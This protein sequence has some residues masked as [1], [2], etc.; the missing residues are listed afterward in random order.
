MPTI[1]KL[2]DNAYVSGNVALSL[3]KG[4]LVIFC[5]HWTW[6]TSSAYLYNSGSV[7]IDGVALSN[8]YAQYIA[9]NGDAKG[10]YMAIF[11]Y[12]V[13]SSGSV[14]VSLSPTDTIAQERYIQL[15]AIEIVPSAG[16]QF[17][18][19]AYFVGSATRAR[20]SST[21]THPIAV[22]NSKDDI[23]VGL[24]YSLNSNSTLQIAWDSPATERVDMYVNAYNEVSVAT[25]ISE[26]DSDVFSYTQ[27][28]GNYNGAVAIAVRELS[29]E[30]EMIW[31]L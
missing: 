26:N 6:N 8:S 16:K 7:L 19:G 31:W 11:P 3:T 25:Q 30:S 5:V 12:L 9:E 22:S 18:N 2:Y 15:T 24:A 27:S 29:F 4:N 1:T 10:D 21:G 17:V 20:D 28:Y 23:F 14:N 13:P